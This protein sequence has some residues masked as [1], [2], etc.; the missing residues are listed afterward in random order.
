MY[1]IE[2]RT[3]LKVHPRNSFPG[4][5]MPVLLVALV[6]SACSITP[7]TIEAVA[8]MNYREMNDQ[9]R[10]AVDGLR[11][12]FP[13]ASIYPNSQMEIW[14]KSLRPDLW[15]NTSL[16]PADNQR[17]LGELALA[18]EQNT[19]ASMVA[20]SQSKISSQTTLNAPSQD[21]GANPT[22]FDSRRSE[23]ANGHPAY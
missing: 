5:V 2:K 3:A 12:E 16:S 14:A 8:G 11:Q 21:A 23:A 18:R 20:S 13:D 19:Q 1:S 9:Q 15:P 6:L 22:V 17:V 10:A 7:A 4:L